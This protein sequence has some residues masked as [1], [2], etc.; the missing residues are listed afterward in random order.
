MVETAAMD[1]AG[2]KVQVLLS[3]RETTGRYTICQVEATGP[4]GAP[5]HMHRYEDGFFYILD[6]TF[7]FEVGGEIIPAPPGTS[8]FIRREASYALRNVGPGRGRLL[9]AAHPGGMDLLFRDLATA[10]SNGSAS[11]L[12]TVGPILEKHGIVI[13]SDLSRD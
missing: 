9:I 13:S 3:S 4:V 8:F 1:I 7:E 6:G 12:K 5:L 10:Q 11:G 2:A